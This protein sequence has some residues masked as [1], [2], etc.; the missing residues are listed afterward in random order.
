MN[1]EPDRVRD[2]AHRRKVIASALRHYHFLVNH[3]I[4]EGNSFAYMVDLAWTVWSEIP[5]RM[6][7]EACKEA[8]IEQGSYAPAIALVPKAYR[9][10][11]A[12]KGERWVDLGRE[13]QA[14]Y[15][16]LLSSPDAAPASKAYVATWLA[17]LKTLHPHLH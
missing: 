7:S 6:I 16:Y 8:A 14:R 3:P 4:P 10:L 13:D 12:S 9:K 1:Q 17:E 11:V 15:A 2:A 5:T